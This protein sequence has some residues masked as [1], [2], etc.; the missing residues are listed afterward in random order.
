MSYYAR[1]AEAEF[2][3]RIRSVPEDIEGMVRLFTVTNGG[4]EYYVEATARSANW[5]EALPVFAVFFATFRPAG[6]S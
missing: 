2:T 3:I 4:Q 1:A 5:Q 6:K